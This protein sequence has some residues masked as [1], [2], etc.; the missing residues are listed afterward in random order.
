MCRG[1]SQIG[2]FSLDEKWKIATLSAKPA[3][4]GQANARFASDDLDDDNYAGDDDD[5]D[6][7]DDDDDAV[8]NND[9]QKLITIL[10]TPDNVDDTHADWL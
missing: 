4:L 10:T 2:R 1:N 7:D 9:D 5:D 8:N 3:S 6:S